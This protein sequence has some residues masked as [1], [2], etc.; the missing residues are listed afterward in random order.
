MKANES[1]ALGRFKTYTTVLAVLNVLLV[2]AALGLM[3]L[4]VVI[5]F[6]SIV[7]NDS[8]NVPQ[9]SAPTVHALFVSGLVALILVVWQFRARRHLLAMLPGA[10]SSMLSLGVAYLVLAVIWIWRVGMISLPLGAIVGVPLAAIGL[11]WVVVFAGARAKAEFAGEAGAA[12]VLP[13][14]V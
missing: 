5:F 14:A 7:F 3:G 9:A 12:E 10:R 6:A 2:I 11:W 1:A 13:P 4:S 8:G